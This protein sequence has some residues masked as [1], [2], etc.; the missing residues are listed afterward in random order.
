MALGNLKDLNDYLFAQLDRLDNIDTSDEFELE[1]EAKRAY[2]VC[3][4]SAQI[5]ANA[6]VVLK[7]VKVRN[8]MVEKDETLP[9]LLGE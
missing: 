3:K 4:V 5:V 8:E 1:T 7:V 9:L 2:A 6:N